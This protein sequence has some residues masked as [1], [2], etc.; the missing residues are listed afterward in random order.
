MIS[1]SLVLFRLHHIRRL[2]GIF[3][4]DLFTQNK[5]CNITNKIFAP[6]TL[7]EEGIN[8]VQVSILQNKTV[9]FNEDGS[10]KHPENRKLNSKFVGDVMLARILF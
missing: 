9:V 3:D 10:K 8:K 7:Q 6:A 5:A 1:L 2:I 4:V